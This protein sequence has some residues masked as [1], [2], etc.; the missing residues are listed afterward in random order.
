[1]RHCAAP[2]I[3]AACCGIH[4][5]GRGGIG[6]ARL[7]AGPRSCP[8]Q[9]DLFAGFAEPQ[10]TPIGREEARA[11]LL[12]RLERFLARHTGGD[13]LG[14]RLRGEQLAA[15]V[16]FMRMLGA[17]RYDLVVANPPYQGT[18]KLADA[19]WVERHYPL[20]KA[21]LYAAFLLRG[22]ELV[23]AGGVSAMLTMRNWMF[24]K[25]YAALRAHL[26]ER[27][28]LRALGDFDR[29]AFEDVPDEVVSVAVSVFRKSEPCGESVAICPTP[30]DDSSRDAYRTARKR[31]ATLLHIG[32]E[33]FEPAALQVVPEWT[34]VYWWTKA[35]LSKYSELPRIGGI[36]PAKAGLQTANDTRFLRRPWEPADGSRLPRG[37]WTVYTKGAEGRQWIEP[38]SYLIH[39][40]QNGLDIKIAEINGKQ[41]ARPQ[42]EHLF[43]KRGIAINT[44]GTAFGARFHRWSGIFGDMGRSLFPEDISHVL[45]VLNSSAFRADMQSLNPTIHFTVGDVNRLPLFPIADADAIF[46]TIERAFTE[47]ESHREPSVEFKRPGPS[48]WRHAQEWAQTAVDRPE[49]A[50]LPD[51]APEYDLEPPTDHLSF[52]LGV[53][54][55]RFGGVRV[56]A[57]RASST[58][59][60]PI[61]RMRCPTAS[62]SSTARSIQK[63]GA[64]AWVIRPLPHC[65]RLGSSTAQPSVP[66]ASR[67]ASGWHKTFS[68]VK[69]GIGRCTRTARST[70]RCP[71]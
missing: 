50:P 57:G 15:G 70:G 46:A 31:T 17:G 5:R 28:D 56:W 63:T 2:T 40:H 22:L 58:P 64:T 10:R 36:C 9:G 61:S 7:G 4:P 1:M 60:A 54:L 3:W 48:P 8:A 45:C 24:I 19:R 13:D 27:F 32:R 11:T 49:G 38:L 67:C 47:H 66:G 30:R 18:A 29:G 51:Y 71:R 12:D 62:V 55:G 41:A 25:Q 65:T 59:G 53:A 21:D 35:K 52:A 23:R 37:R 26:L 33:I 42:N 6:A 68:G 39:W 20:G 44:A 34:L 16:R 14:L 43:F 69:T